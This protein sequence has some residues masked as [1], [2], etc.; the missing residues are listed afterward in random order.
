MTPSNRFPVR[1]P[2]GT[3][4][5]AVGIHRGLIVDDVELFAVDLADGTI[6]CFTPDNS[7]SN[8]FAIV[9][10]A[11]RVYGFDNNIDAVMIPVFSPAASAQMGLFKW[12][13][14]LSGLVFSAG[15]IDFTRP[16]SGYALRCSEFD[17]FSALS[18]EETSGTRLV[19]GF[20]DGDNRVIAGC[21]GENVVIEFNSGP[22]DFG[23]VDAAPL[24]YVSGADDDSFADSWVWY[25]AGVPY[26]WFEANGLT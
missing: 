2:D 23:F 7:A 21:N 11:V 1:R 15:E 6:G 3:T 13:I 10:G 18:L 8:S 26:S 20:R 25:L 17:E 24:T 19:F 12:A 4:T 14:D 22:A 5:E 16:Y 9:N